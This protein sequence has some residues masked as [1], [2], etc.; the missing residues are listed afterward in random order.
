MFNSFLAIKIAPSGEAVILNEQHFNGMAPHR[1]HDICSGVKSAVATLIGVGYRKNVLDR[2]A[3][4][5]TY[6]PELK[7]TEW[8]GTTLGH[9]LDMESGM[10]FHEGIEL[11]NGRPVVNLEKSDNIRAIRSQD[12]STDPNVPKGYKAFLKSL[13]RRCDPGLE[14]SYSEPDPHVAGWAAESVLKQ[15]FADAFSQH[16]YRRLGPEQDAYVTCDWLGSTTYNLSISPRDWG[17]WA[18]MCLQKGIVNGEEIV[19]RRFFDEIDK[20][21]PEKLVGTPFV[22]YLVPRGSIF[23][24]YFLRKPDGTYMVSGAWGQGC[25]IDPAR[26]HVIVQLGSWRHLEK[27][28]LLI[29]DLLAFE[30]V[31]AA[32]SR[33]ELE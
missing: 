13:T 16:I 9:L 14:F 20:G 5:S 4:V 1:L 3:D 19:P 23:R 12:S 33:F 8:D 18:Q 11:V 27:P 26:G 10:Q 30:H 7:D 31:S 17:R 24:N 15:N 28:E 22:P 2:E 25:N 32:M 29:D 21:D 6:I